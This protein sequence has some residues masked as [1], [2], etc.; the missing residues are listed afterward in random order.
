MDAPIKNLRIPLEHY[1]DGKVRTQITAGLASMQE[2]GSVDAQKVRIE[3]FDRDGAV[4]G[5]VEAEACYVDRE[6]QMV[7]STNLVRVTRKGM[8][9]TGQGFEWQA[10]EQSF[11][12]LAQAR[13]V[14][15]RAAG[16]KFWKLP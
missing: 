6:K 4:E 14:F 12:I 7:T 16:D 11:K 5:L 13:V 1:E 9:V 8:S 15:L 2:G 3:M 10:A